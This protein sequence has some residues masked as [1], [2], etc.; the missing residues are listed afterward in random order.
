VFG[1]SFERQWLIDPEGST[2]LSV[3]SSQAL[4]LVESPDLA[5]KGAISPVAAA[6]SYGKKGGTVLYLLS[7]F[8]KQ[9]TEDDAFT[10]QNLLLNFLIEA[11]EC[12]RGRLK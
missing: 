4:A 1:P 3:V 12:M 7:H 6:F 8:K 10:L 5:R 2:G 11:Q 9:K